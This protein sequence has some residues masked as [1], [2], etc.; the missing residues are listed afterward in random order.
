LAFDLWIGQERLPAG[1]QLVGGVGAQCGQIM[2]AGQ[3]LQG[4]FGGAAPKEQIIPP[5]HGG[6]Q[7]LGSALVGR[8][9][10]QMTKHAQ[11]SKGR[12]R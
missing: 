6:Q 2:L 11:R 7:P 4:K 1:A 9:V 3:Q 5:T 8:L 12:Q 10:I